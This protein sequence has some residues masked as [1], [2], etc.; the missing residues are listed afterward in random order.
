MNKETQ[1]LLAEAGFEIENKIMFTL[2]K[3]LNQ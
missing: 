2:N 3:A 1:N